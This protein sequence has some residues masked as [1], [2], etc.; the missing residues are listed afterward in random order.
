V[1]AL[2]AE[3]ATHISIGGA[4]LAGEALRAGLVDEINLFLNPIAVGGGKPALPDGLRIGLELLDE[5]R[6]ESGVV[7]VHYRVG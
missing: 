1:R 7:H 2:K 6:F 4:E 5:H 3:A